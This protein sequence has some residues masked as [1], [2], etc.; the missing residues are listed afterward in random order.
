MRDIDVK[1]AK[2]HAKL[3]IY[4]RHLAQARNILIEIMPLL[5]RPYLSFSCGKDSSVVAHLLL[6]MDIHIHYRFLSSGETRL[7][8]NIDTIID[9][10]RGRGA[11]IEEICIDRVFSP[12]WQ[13]AG[14]AEQKAAGKNDMNRAFAGE[15]DGVLMGLRSEESRN[16]ERSLRYHVTPSLPKHCYRY[17][18]GRIRVCPIGSW[19]TSD[20]AAYLTEHNIP[21]LDA[22]RDEGIDARTTARLTGNAVRQGAVGALHR[23]DPAAYQKLIK[24][25]PELA[26]LRD[27]DRVLPG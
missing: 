10:F 5:S 13:H 12:E 14:W 25:F 16:R 18:S 7:L 11:E 8:H 22:Y 1:C 23:R 27:L 6:S 24:R 4:Q 20:V 9:W 17:A 19:S 15:W 26:S 3:P 2:L 21:V